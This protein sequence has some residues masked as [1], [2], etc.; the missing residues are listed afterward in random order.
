MGGVCC[1]GELTE[2]QASTGFQVLTGA[3][4]E[5]AQRAHE[6]ATENIKDTEAGPSTIEAHLRAQYLSQAAYLLGDANNHT[7][8]INKLQAS[9]YQ[10]VFKAVNVLQGIQIFRGKAGGGLGFVAT[11]PETAEFAPNSLVV[12]FKGTEVNST[13]ISANFEWTPQDLDL[14]NQ[15]CQVSKGYAEIY[16]DLMFKVGMWD[17][18]TEA[19]KARGTKKIVVAGHS[20]GGAVGAIAAVHLANFYQKEQ[21][22]GLYTI[23]APRSFHQDSAADIERTLGKDMFQRCLNFGDFAPT[24]PPQNLK[25]RHIGV[26]LYLNEGIA[27]STV[28]GT[29]H[30]DDFTGGLGTG[31]DPSMHL[32]SNYQARL[33]TALER[34]RAAR[35]RAA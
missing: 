10:D 27:D 1:C 3:Q 11:S 6:L 4:T 5:K 2:N 29:L 15:K 20:L 9:G 7:E 24:L 30:S 26:A 21:E 32:V 16:N 22:I 12:V 28:L 34:A 13:E 19:V 25:F 17:A 23:G 35:A 8:V 18:I 33:E 14:S 31:G